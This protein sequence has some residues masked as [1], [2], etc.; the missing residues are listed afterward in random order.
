M[1]INGIK[2][3]LNHGQFTQLTSDFFYLLTLRVTGRTPIDNNTDI[4]AICDVIKSFLR[5][6]PEPVIPFS[7]YFTFISSASKSSALPG[8]ESVS[9]RA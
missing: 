9:R 1:E 5:T 6:L 4:Y 3:A 8:D 2:E 7:M